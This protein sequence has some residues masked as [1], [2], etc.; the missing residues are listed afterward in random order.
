MKIDSKNE[1]NIFEGYKNAIIYKDL[2]GT[3]HAT[4]NDF[5]LSLQ[6]DSHHDFVIGRKKWKSKD[7]TAKNMIHISLH[8]QD[9]NL[10]MSLR[11]TLVTALIL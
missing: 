9:A 11:A 6:S 10:E 3:W 5:R 7:Q 1:I 4:S 2:N 8:Y